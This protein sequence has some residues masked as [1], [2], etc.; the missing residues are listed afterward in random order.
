M[1]NEVIQ[2]LKM[3]R[4]GREIEKSD[5]LNIKRDN[6]KKF[7]EGTKDANVPNGEVKK[8]YEWMIDKNTNTHG[9]VYL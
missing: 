5:A 9:V 1:S 6:K 3:S 4:K 8:E 2:N 7:E